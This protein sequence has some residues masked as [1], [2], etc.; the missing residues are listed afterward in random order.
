MAADE[1]DDVGGRREGVRR[2]VRDIQ[3]YNL[4]RHNT[5][6]IEAKCSRFLAFESVDE[7]RKVAKILCELDSPYI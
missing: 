2:E 4:K 6:G 7:A 3:D 5:F 1:N